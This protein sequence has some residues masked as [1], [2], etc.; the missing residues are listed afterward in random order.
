MMHKKG[1]FKRG[2]Y[3]P[4]N[5]HKYIGR[6]TPNYRSSWELHFFQWCDRNPNVLEW[7]AEAV[8]IPYISPVDSKTHR[9]FVDNILILKEGNK[10][11]KYLVEI[12]PSKQT[13]PPTITRKKKRET[14]LHEQIT[15]E[16]NKAKWDAANN[17][18]IKNGYKFIIITEK[19]LFPE[20]K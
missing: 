18:S 5:K 4:K 3:R 15:Y 6:S 12:K 7:A 11:T 9:Y 14:I 10:N 19:E 17:W 16:I 8:V 1:S 20:K 13:I 2:I